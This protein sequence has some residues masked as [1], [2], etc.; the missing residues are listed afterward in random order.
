MNTVLVHPKVPAWECGPPLTEASQRAL[1][2]R[3]V[4][5]ACKW[6][7]QVGDTATIAPFPLILRDD[8]GAE[9]FRLAERLAAELIAAERE[10]L[11][12]PDRIARL[13]L[14]RAVARVL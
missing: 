12:R 4:L 13:G 14:P 10:I 9:L 11:R 3:L 7:P 1:R 6:D 8:V 5:E 2:T